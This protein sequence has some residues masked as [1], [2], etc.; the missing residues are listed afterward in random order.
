[1]TDSADSRPPLDTTK[2][3]D[4][5]GDPIRLAYAVEALASTDSTNRVVAD[6]ARA[7]A[8]EG[9]VVVAEAQTAGRGRLARTWETPPGAA[10]TFSVLLR[11]KHRPE[12]WPWLSLLAAIG[13]ARGL[14]SLGLPGLGVAEVGV[15]WPNDVLVW[16]HGV[17]RKVAGLLLERV[18]T[19][20]GPAAVLG[21]G[22]NID[23]T[24]AELPVPTAT[25]LRLVTEGT[26][27]RLDVLAAVLRAW[28]DEYVASHSDGH[29]LRAGYRQWCRT[30]GQQVR[31][32]LP[33]SAPLV[34]EAVDIDRFGRLLVRHTEGE[35][36]VAAGDVVHVRP[37]R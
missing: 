6:R 32:E 30:L 13:V 24:S 19:D 36:A 10:L 21:I 12:E 27:S 29:T 31:V 3:P 25:S 34:G 8:P 2:L 15:K 33:A 26:V 9:L 23:Q 4:L 22:I 37:A 28:D 18:E 14:T 5:L 1:M 11:P 7:G 16:D 35:T 20:R 17:E